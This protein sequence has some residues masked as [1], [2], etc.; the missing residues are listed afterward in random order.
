M[1]DYEIVKDMPIPTKI[2]G[3]NPNSGNSLSTTVGSLDVGDAIIRS[4]AGLSTGG[5]YARSCLTR[6]KLK[7][8]ERNYTTRV[9]VNAK[10][11]KC[12]GIWRLP[13][14]PP[15]SLQVVAE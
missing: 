2:N 10:G 6:C 4:L 11:E 1:A 5:A 15:A 12:F 8:P 3:R 9:F 13:D 7:H 14:T